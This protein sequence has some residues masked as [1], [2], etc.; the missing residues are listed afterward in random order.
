MV[1]EEVHTFQQLLLLGGPSVDRPG[2]TWNAD[3]TEVRCD[4]CDQWFNMNFSNEGPPE[5]RMKSHEKQRRHRRA[6]ARIEEERERKNLELLAEEKI[7]AKVS[8][9]L[10]CLQDHPMFL[11]SEWIPLGHFLKIFK[12]DPE[13]Y[14]VDNFSEYLVSRECDEAEVISEALAWLDLSL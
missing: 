12:V 6:L 13:C 9:I 8:E 14:C 1:S 7:E 10:E 3:R 2:W 11:W 4:P 5:F